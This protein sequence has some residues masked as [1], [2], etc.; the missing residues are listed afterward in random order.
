MRRSYSICSP[1]K[2]SLLEVLIKKVET[3]QFS[4]YAHHHFE[5]GD[6]VEV[7]APQGQFCVEPG[8]L[9]GKNYLLIAAGVGITPIISILQLLLAE[10]EDSRVTL[11]Y[12]STTARQIIFRERLSWL[13]SQYLERMQWINV[14]SRETQS[15]DL[16]SGRLT[17]EKMA[18]LSE[19][20]TAPES[21]DEFYLCGP[22]PLTAELV[23]FLSS[24]GISQEHV[25]TE[26]FYNSQADA[27][28]SIQRQQQRKI[29][30][31]GKV[32]SV[33]VR[34]GGREAT[35]TL[36]PDGGSILDVALA[37]GL[38]LPFSCKGGVCATCKARVLAGQVDMDINH[39]LSADQLA[40][41][42]V[43]TCQAHPISAT[44]QL[45]FDVN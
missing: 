13:K 27:Q 1:V 2:S 26:L 21:F 30:H 9:E 18:Q 25:H 19:C 28:Q 43:L 39:G 29:E 37:A 4:N 38:D 16:F 45:D 3:G 34:Q 11:L 32:C 44:V 31:A 23:H 20:L 36:A 22:P 5:P 15:A 10:S 14:L 24:R 17:F 12:G 7:M 42:F 40:R 6:K 41:G 33:T 35:L 8:S